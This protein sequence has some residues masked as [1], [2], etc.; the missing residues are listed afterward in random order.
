MIE[1]N[2]ERSNGLIRTLFHRILHSD[3]QLTYDELVGS[4]E[5]R[6]T[7]YTYAADNLP[8]NTFLKSLRKRQG[9]T[10][11]WT[12]PPTHECT[13]SQAAAVQRYQVLL[14]SQLT[15]LNSDAIFFLE[16]TPLYVSCAPSAAEAEA[17]AGAREG[18]KE[19][20]DDH[21]SAHHRGGGKTRFTD[22]C[23]I[24]AAGTMSDIV[25]VA[26]GE[27]VAKSTFKIA[28]H[29][30]VM[31]LIGHVGNITTPFAHA[32]SE[33]QR[34][35]QEQEEEEEEYESD[36]EAS[37]SEEE[38]EEEEEEEGSV[39]APAASRSSTSSSHAAQGGNHPH[40]YKTAT[41]TNTYYK[42]ALR[43][44]LEKRIQRQRLLFPPGWNPTHSASYAHGVSAAMNDLN[45]LVAASV[46]HERD[47][48]YQHAL[49]IVTK[50]EV[51]EK[52]LT[53]K[54]QRSAHD[55]AALNRITR[56]LAEER[57]DLKHYTKADTYTSAVAR[58]VLRSAMK[59]KLGEV[60][61]EHA[62]K[63]LL[64]CEMAYLGYSDKN[65][66]TRHEIV[67]DARAIYASE[68]KDDAKGHAHEA[69]KERD[70]GL[71]G[72]RLGLCPLPKRLHMY[73]QPSAWP[74]KSTIL[75]Y[76][77]DVIAPWAKEHEQREPRQRHHPNITG[78]STRAS[79]TTSSKGGKGGSG[80]GNQ[81]CILV[82]N[83]STPHTHTDV[84]S[85]IGDL[86]V[87]LLY[88]PPGF[89]K[90]LH[91]LYA[92]SFREYHAKISEP[93]TECCKD[94]GLGMGEASNT[95]QTERERS[96]AARAAFEA[97]KHLK[98]TIIPH[99]LVNILTFAP[100]KH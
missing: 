47:V 17:G 74:D 61:R 35:G 67:D 3:R 73:T 8:S 27:R 86:H 21:A 31:H 52:A 98:R 64:E 96:F 45:K 44:M 25:V 20:E 100:K 97:R 58:R 93:D 7:N 48:A 14:A 56:E 89:T 60:M 72:H 95:S 68:A 53:A 43:S 34:V 2:E 41:L 80:G 90:Q 69:E 13:A 36:E 40:T 83:K 62:E 39:S 87:T 63:V 4:K 30:E 37:D 79:T 59:G 49:D 77:V 46:E 92:E 28:E 55:T 91:P 54:K 38:E 1:N 57:K 32:G 75:E 26:Q 11:S 51:Q 71:C 66:A 10:K 70:R 12:L 19:G 82:V 24:T 22:M 76:A 15:S 65:E 78:S 9:F 85:A 16:E 42:D 88:T 33:A 5:A 23:G 18:K 50:L 29:G 94:K 99:A 84:R 6:L 81:G